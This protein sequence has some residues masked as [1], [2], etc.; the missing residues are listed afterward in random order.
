MQAGGR[1]GVS[2][3]DGFT[4]LEIVCA[5][6]IVALLA[7]VLLP[8]MPIGTSRPRL[9]AHAIAIASLLSTDRTAAIRRQVQVSTE[10]DARARSVRSGATGRTL[11]IPD[12][13]VFEAIL[14]ELCNSRPA[15]STIGFLPTGM[16]CGGT[17]V[18]TRLGVAYEITVNWLTGGVEVGSR[19]AL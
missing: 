17:I 19:H 18:L 1:D 15:L 3:Q 14:P 6:A 13:V 4:L 7:A 8:R 11:R 12:D 16:S 9:E 2:S 10:V 5:V